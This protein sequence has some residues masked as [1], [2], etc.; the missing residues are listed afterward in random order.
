MQA[1]QSQELGN[2]GMQLLQQKQLLEQALLSATA[3][4]TISEVRAQCLLCKCSLL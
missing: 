1:L 4:P 3:T 2:V